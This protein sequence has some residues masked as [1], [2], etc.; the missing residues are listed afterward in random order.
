MAAPVDPNAAPVWAN[1]APDRTAPAWADTSDV[2][3]TI[4]AVEHESELFKPYSTL[5]EPIRETILRD[6]RAV[7][8][9]LKIVMQP[10]DRRPTVYSM[11]SLA[12]DDGELSE[13]DKKVITEL[14]DWDLWGPL[15]LCLVLAVALSFRAPS[16][17]S[18]LVFAAVFCAVWVGGT[19][20]T[21]NAQL[22]GGTISFFQSLCVLGY[23]LFPLTLAALVIGIFK[24]VVHTW[25]FLDM[26]V[27]GLGFAWAL[28]VSS[29]FIGLYIKPERRLMA[30][31][32]VVYFYIFIS[33]MILLF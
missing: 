13:N 7:G 2:S 16:E 11:V 4:S 9:K 14:K 27:V 22:L 17:Q 19:V 21:V 12:D 1:A 23:S 32:P 15:V 24:M 28:R 5:D 18:A 6:V 25:L 10:L 29:I 8:A 20:V 26:I 31:Y 3:D 30:L 33:W